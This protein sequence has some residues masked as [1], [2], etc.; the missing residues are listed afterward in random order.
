MQR[1]GALR[2]RIV[3]GALAIGRRAADA[4]ASPRSR[5]STSPPNRPSPTWRPSPRIANAMNLCLVRS[6]GAGCARGLPAHAG[7]GRAAQAGPAGSSSV[8]TDRPKALSRERSHGLPLPRR[9]SK[10]SRA[11]SPGATASRQALRSQTETRTKTATQ[12]RPVRASRA[13][14]AGSIC[15]ERSQSGERKR[16]ASTCSS[17]VVSSEADTLRI[18]LDDGRVVDYRLDWADGARLPRVPRVH[19]RSR[20]CA[21]PTTGAPA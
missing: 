2:L 16:D 5:R 17:G 19:A 18:T 1:P 12:S 11:S 20:A 4:N 8:R 13:I 9:G 7:T 21:R 15:V 10:P 3:V 14:R 6:G